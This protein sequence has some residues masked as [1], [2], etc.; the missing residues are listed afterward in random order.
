MMRYL[1]E[2]N[3]L[4]R[5][6]R[7][8]RRM[9]PA[10]II[11]IGVLYVHR[12]GLLAPNDPLLLVAHRAALATIGFCVAHIVRQPAFPYLDLKQEMH[13]QNVGALV[14]VGLIYT[15]FILGCTLGF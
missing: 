7:E 10:L 12:A 9:G 2:D 5:L 3:R 8:L 4:T 13:R 14:M 1:H 11:S 6:I 15:A